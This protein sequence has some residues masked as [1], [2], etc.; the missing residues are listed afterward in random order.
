M[1]LGKLFHSLGPAAGNEALYANVD[2]YR[3][4]GHMSDVDAWSCWVFVLLG[5][6]SL[7]YCGASPFMHLYMMQ[8]ILNWILYGIFSQ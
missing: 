6:K 3:M 1:F 5:S 7:R 4:D 2:L 8:A